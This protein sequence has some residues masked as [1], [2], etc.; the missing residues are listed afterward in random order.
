L[1]VPEAAGVPLNVITPADH[2]AVTPAGRLLATPIPVAPEVV[3]VIIGNGRPKQIVGEAEGA[4]TVFSGVMPIVRFAVFAHKPAV[5]VNVYVVVAVLLIAGDH[6]PVMGGILVEES[7]SAAIAAPLQ[8]GP[9][10]SKVG[11]TGL[12]AVRTTELSCTILG[13]LH[14]ELRYV[15]LPFWENATYAPF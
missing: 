2:E 4:E 12:G 8:N 15:A 10:A 3:K 9:R 7:G 1:N 5:G 11:V 13:A 14:A 6:V